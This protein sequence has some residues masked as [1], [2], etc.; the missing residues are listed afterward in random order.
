M[1]VQ[2]EEFCRWKGQDSKQKQAIEYT[3]AENKN[4]HFFQHKIHTFI[5][6]LSMH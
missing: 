1:L 3:L 5:A 6:S 2:P 4:C